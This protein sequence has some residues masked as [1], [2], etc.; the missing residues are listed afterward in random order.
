M[1]EPHTWLVARGLPEQTLEQCLREG[2]DLGRREHVEKVLLQTFRGAAEEGPEVVWTQPTF[3]LRFRLGPEPRPLRIEVAVLLRGI[4]YEDLI[5]KLSTKM[6]GQLEERRFWRFFDA[7]TKEP[8][9][10]H[11]ARR[12]RL[13]GKGL[14]SI[15]LSPEAL[16]LHTRAASGLQLLISLAAASEVDAFVDEVP[17]LPQDDVI[18]GWRNLE[19]VTPRNNRLF[20]FRFGGAG[21]ES[22]RDRVQRWA[23]ETGRSTGMLDQDVLVVG[24]RTPEVVPVA[25]CAAHLHQVWEDSLASGACLWREAF[26]VYAPDGTEVTRHVATVTI[27]PDS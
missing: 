27:Q 14:V 9:R 2:E 11:P 8:V 16:L 13:S 19:I 18:F 12:R 5:S 1:T 10:W 20:L 25:E 26:F 17:L 7:A 4:G 3:E 22:A 6:R 23:L 15:E 24:G 21:R